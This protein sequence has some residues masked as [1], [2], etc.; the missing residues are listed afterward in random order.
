MF[1]FFEQGDE[2]SE[3]L[4]GLLYA[5]RIFLM[6]GKDGETLQMQCLKQQPQSL[7]NIQDRQINAERQKRRY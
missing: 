1:L 6:N 3:F 2:A 7:I 5:V 4:R